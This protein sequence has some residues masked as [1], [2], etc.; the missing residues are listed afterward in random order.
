[1]NP[2]LLVALSVVVVVLL[3][4][5]FLIT[6]QQGATTSTVSQSSTTV[7]T[8]AS[9]VNSP[10]NLQLRLSVNAS[11]T[12]GSH[13]NVTVSIRV[14][15]YNTLATAN[16]VSKSTGWGLGGLSLGTC[17]TEIYPFGV[18]LYSGTYTVGNVSQAQPLHIYPF[19]PCPMLIRL[20]TGYLFQPT[21]DLAVVLPGGQNATATPMS[22]NVTATSEYGVG[23]NLSSSPSPLGPGTYTVAA[24]DEWGS[25]VVT[26]FT[27]GAPTGSSST[28]TAVPLTGTLDA[29]FSV[30]PTQPVC[31]A[32]ATVGPAPSTYSSIEAVVTPSPSGLASTLPI[33]WTTN[34]CEVSGSLQASLAPG[35]Y[36]LSL[37]SCTFMGCSSALPKSFVVV[38]GQSTSL[39]VSIDTGIR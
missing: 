11:T 17:G 21:S 22:A 13:G 4:G 29:T 34:G 9:Y 18:A 14:D 32:N 7:Q 16:N 26:R 33:A 6:M 27:I 15:E 5:T 38:V 23:G 36:S 31:S 20:V 39:D 1:L 19:V 35:S 28:S 3:A 30:G 10:Q 8:G 2:R 37:S 12:G 24:G 25:V